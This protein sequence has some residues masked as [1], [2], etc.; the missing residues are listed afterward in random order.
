MTVTA[1]LGTMHRPSCFN[2]YPFQGMFFH[3][4]LYD[5]LYYINQLKMDTF[6]RQLLRSFRSVY[7]PNVTILRSLSKYTR[8]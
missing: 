5:R 6:I 1:N 8:V 3:S 7:I 2:G 4:L